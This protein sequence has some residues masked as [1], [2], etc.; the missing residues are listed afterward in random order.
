MAWTTSLV[1]SLRYYLG[2][3]DISEY[4]DIAL[5][6]FLVYGA[7]E[8]IADTPVNGYTA[9]F[10]V[11][12]I[13][14]DPET[15]SG[16]SQLILLKAQIIIIRGE[17]RRYSRTAGYKITDDRSTIDGTSHLNALKDLL[18]QLEKDYTNAQTSYGSGDGRVYRAIIAPNTP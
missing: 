1:N 17:I 9:D 5:Q 12:N 7:A 11:L 6:T 2:S 10:S 18:K 14:P 16:I 8:A 13:S 15:N 3:P 4:S